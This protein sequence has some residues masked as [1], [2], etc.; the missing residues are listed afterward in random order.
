[1]RT[2]R[3]LNEL[4]ARLGG[5]LRLVEEVDHER[6]VNRQ[7]FLVQPLA[8]HSEQ[9]LEARRGLRGQLAGA[10]LRERGGICPI[11]FLVVAGVVAGNRAGFRCAPGLKE[12]RK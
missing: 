4:V 2:L 1:L 12:G 3:D 11:E 8:A 7:V 9:E 5:V 6:V 10:A